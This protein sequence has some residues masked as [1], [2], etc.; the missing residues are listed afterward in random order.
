MGVVY[1][2][3]RDDDEFNKEVAIKI[4]SPIG[5]HEDWIGR[6]RQERNILARLDH[7]NIARLLDGGTSDEGFPFV[8]MEYVEGRP[9]HDW[10]DEEGLGLDQRI[11]LFRQVCAAVHEAHRNLVVHRDLKPA[12][13]LVGRDGRPRLLD[14]GIAKLLDPSPDDLAASPPTATAGRLMTPEYASPEQVRGLPVSTA[15]DVYSLGVM[16]YEL[17]SGARPYRL[18]GAPPAEIDRLI[19]EVDPPAPSTVP[20]DGGRDAKTRTDSWR[21]RLRG[22]LDRIVAKA[23]HKDPSR[24]YASAEA[25]SEDLRRF[26]EGLPVGA[27]DDTW[28]YRTGKFVRR[29]RYAVTAASIAIVALAGFGVAMARQ[30]ARIADERDRVELERNK[31]QRIADFFVQMFHTRD[32]SGVPGRDLPASRLL[33]AGLDRLDELDEDPL[34]RARLLEAVGDVYLYLDMYDDAEPLLRESFDLRETHDA[35]P[36]DMASSYH[37]L[38]KLAYLRGDMDAALE[39][40]RIGHDLRLADLGADDP[41]VASSLFGIGTVHRYRDDLEEAAAAFAQALDIMH[42][43]GADDASGELDQL[44]GAIA[45]TYQAMGRLDDA[46][47]A[48]RELLERSRRIRGDGHV[49]TAEAALSLATLLRRMDGR[50]AEADPLYREAIEIFRET[51]GRHSATSQAINN[52]AVFLRGSGR[53]E[54]ARPLHYEALEMDREL[55]GDVHP[56]VGIAL[57]NVGAYERG[58]GDASRALEMYEEAIGIF[59]QTVGREHWLYWTAV[60]GRAMTREELGEYDE[61]AADWRAA[62]DGH[63]RTLGADHPRSVRACDGLEQ[64]TAEH[65]GGR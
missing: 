36:L 58:W 8:V 19:C 13:V 15:S 45:D 31:A 51:L 35:G 50:E 38:G 60:Q 4:V 43:S 26:L 20:S 40:Y 27:R 42:R 49:E 11:E 6:F 52:Y 28:T 17:L 57:C 63:R 54:E 29:H 3:V 14:F 9:I 22:D 7:P 33:E 64:F 34:V 62:C 44:L 12:N 53:P 21:T 32:E 41:V 48:F 39:N 18:Q 46:E 56:A 5:I 23:M 59:D 24:R 16:L 47:R 2:A 1:R 10:C 55:R 25:L 61:A 65:G 30:S 37:E